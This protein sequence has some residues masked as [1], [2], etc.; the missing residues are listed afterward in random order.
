[1]IPGPSPLTIDTEGL[2][3]VVP[4]RTGLFVFAVKC[5]EFRDGVKIG[6]V[7]RDFQML[8]IDCP[9]PGVAPQ[10]TIKSPGSEVFYNHMDTLVFKAGDNLCLQAIVSDQDPNEKINL[11]IKPVNFNDP[12]LR[13]MIVAQ[14]VIPEGENS[15]LLEYCVPECPYLPDGIAI[16]DL[17]AED[18]ACSQPLM[19]SIRLFL[20]IE[21]PAN[22]DPYFDGL[23]AVIEKSI[24]L[25]DRYEVRLTGLDDDS[26]S[27]SIDLEPVNFFLEDYGLRFRPVT[28]EDG[29]IE[30]VFSWDASC[31][32][33]DFS[34][35][36]EF[37][38]EF[39][40]NDYDYCNLNKPTVLTIHIIVN[41]A[42][43]T[44]PKVTTSLSDTLV[45]T[46]IE[47]DLV[48]D[49]FAEDPENDPVELKLVGSGYDPNGLGMVFENKTGLGNTTSR[50]AWRLNCGQV[51]LET[52]D[53]YQLYFVAED[54]DL[55]QKNNADTA[56]VTVVVR[57]PRNNAPRVAMEFRYQ[58]ATIEMNP[59][60][61]LEFPV[62]AID[63]DGDTVYLK[64]ENADQLSE[65][66]G[67]EFTAV[68]GQGSAT[69]SF[70]WKPD[71][72]ALG[73]S[74]SPLYYTFNFYTYDNKCFNSRSDSVKVNVIVK[75]VDSQENEF[76]PPNAFSPNGDEHNPSFFIRNLPLDNCNERFQN[77]AIYNRWG[78]LVFQDD[79]RDF[80]WN[81]NGLPTG[82]YFYNIKFSKS[83]YKG[84]ISL[85]R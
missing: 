30:Y 46:R 1:M 74:F 27:L 38:I 85:L 58:Y 7:R 42:L 65:E 48:F 35:Q 22:K 40:L 43:N 4:N 53:T 63:Q 67:L 84:T 16:V 31:D 82:V 11:K 5:E 33:Y 78:D 37:T 8:V 10:L 69:T 23:P 26:D 56:Q 50:Y 44:G 52:E 47:Q 21:G 17:I 51:D 59:G 15:V 75:D 71:C 14:G 9:D 19:D 49:V 32:A 18:D 41:D 72:N 12:N 76:L 55:C 81:G 29:K 13:N 39:K 61:T 70:S 79:N 64:L 66:L 73:S 28:N 45:I 34:T 77:I 6:E 36:N 60:Q 20:K 83:E 80:E 25:G 68:S 54:N 24:S 2:L 62:G 57:P 3:K